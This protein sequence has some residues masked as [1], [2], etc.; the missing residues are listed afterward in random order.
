MNP[1]DKILEDYGLKYEDLNLEERETYNKQHFQLKTLTIDDLKNYV[2][3]MKNS[4][5]LQLCDVKLEEKQD[6]ILKARLLNYILMESFLSS[7]DKAERALRDALSNVK[8]QK[9]K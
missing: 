1:L 8:L 5:S 6:I 3:D 7:P 2:R 9:G 4:I